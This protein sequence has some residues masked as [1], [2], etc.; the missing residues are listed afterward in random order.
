MP[1]T[2]SR[3]LRFSWQTGADNGRCDQ[4][5]RRAPTRFGAMSTA[6][7]P[8]ATVTRPLIPTRTEK[9]RGEHA[10]VRG[11]VEDQRQTGELAGREQ[12]FAGG[13]SRAEQLSE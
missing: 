10:R 8:R 5:H 13:R 12:Q 9:K 2:I 6:N 1:C 4:T 3:P 7:R 11:T